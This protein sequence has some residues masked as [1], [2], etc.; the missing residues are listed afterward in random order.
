MFRVYAEN[1]QVL[2]LPRYESGQRSAAR[3]RVRALVLMDAS[4]ASLGP[5]I[6]IAAFLTDRTIACRRISRVAVL[7][8]SRIQLNKMSDT[9]AKLPGSKNDLKEKAEPQ[10]QAEKN[11]KTPATVTGGEGSAKRN[12]VRKGGKGTTRK[13]GRDE[14]ED[15]T[16][17][18]VVTDPKDPNYDDPNDT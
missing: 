2:V 6:A 12:I 3:S 16:M 9:S 1:K 14:L 8:R 15:G 13:E 10:T 11:D 7:T 4:V 18:D 5:P 17:D